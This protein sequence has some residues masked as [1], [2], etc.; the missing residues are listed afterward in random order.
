MKNQD[1]ELDF[2]NYPI[3]AYINSKLVFIC[4][5]RAPYLLE[6]DLLI[7]LFRWSMQI[8][9]V[10]SVSLTKVINMF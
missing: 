5:N 1:E 3:L 4:V 7:N 9:W 8:D 6:V 2:Y 10:N